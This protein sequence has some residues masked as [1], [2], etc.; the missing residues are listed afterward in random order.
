MTINNIWLSPPFAIAR[1]GTSSTPCPAFMWGESDTSPRGSGKT[2]LM[3]TETLML[4]ETGVVSSETP[5]TLTLKDSE[6]FRPVC[7][8]FELHGEWE[9]SN[10]NVNSGAITKNVLQEAGLSAAD[11]KWKVRVA[12]LK[13][14]HYTLVE[15]EKIIAEIEIAGNDTTKKPLQGVAETPMGQQPLF[16]AGKSLP[17]GEVQLSSPTDEFPEFRLRF[18][19]P[20]G[21]VYGPTNLSER[22]DTYQIPQERLIINP[23]SAWAQF[24][25]TDDSRTNPGGLFATFT[26][27]EN[28]QPVDKSLGLV[29][30]VGDGIISC[31]LNGLTANCRITIGPPDYAPD[32][33][34]LV[35]LADGLK[36]RENR[37]DVQQAEYVADF[38]TTTAEIRDLF[39]RVLETMELM[40][41]DF[42]NLRSQSENAGVADGLG[43]PASAGEGK[44]FNIQGTLT[45]RPLPLTE[46]GRQ[47]HRRFVALEVL[48]DKLRENP[49]LLDQWVRKPM[50][51]ERFYDTKMPALMRGSDRYPMHI[52]QRQY[53]LLKA[54]VQALREQGNPGT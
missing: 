13:P 6:G 2:T 3:P 27:T 35:S 30:D 48:E 11:I 37:T 29:D 40:N 20:K 33:R 1:V 22:D 24:R 23:D 15:H 46:R 28:G 14:F 19:A 47:Q 44:L 8:Y 36:D 32:R 31:E 12:N 50:T 25:L 21:E 38:D 49:D 45:G 5:Q 17:M 39:E 54:W 10:G 42:Q 18:F 16:T 52:T 7:P 41:L 4:S 53:N 43:L 9:D 51:G 26:D 34:P